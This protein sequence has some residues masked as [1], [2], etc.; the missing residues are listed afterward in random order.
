MGSLSI[1]GVDA[2][3]T[4]LLKKRAELE[5]KS[6][7]QL[8]LETMQQHVGL[9]RNKRFTGTFHDLDVL[10]GKWS[11]TEY[12]IIERKIASERQIDD[13]IWK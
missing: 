4:S 10:F 1:R 9:K 11:Q 13:E 2:E 5:N 8:V 6:V 3:L 7:N 12:E